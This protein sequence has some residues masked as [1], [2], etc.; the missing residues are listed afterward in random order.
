MFSPQVKGK[1]FE[2]DIHKFLSNTRSDILLNETQIRAIDSTITAIDHL[3]Y[4]DNVYYCIQDKRLKTPISISDFNHFIKCVE[5]VSTTINHSSKIYAIYL[6]F[7]EFS[8]VANKQLEEENK[9]Y[10]EG[11]SNIEY[12][13][14]VNQTTDSIIKHLQYFLYSNYV[15]SYDADGDCIM[16]KV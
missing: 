9:K 4:S 5:K 10:N 8:S 16:I 11:N 7:T 2:N 6:S 1:I 14:V 15:F 12:I 13:K 3:L